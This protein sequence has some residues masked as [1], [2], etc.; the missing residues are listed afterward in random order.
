MSEANR[1]GIG[2]SLDDF[3]KEEGMLEETQAIATKETVAFQIQQ[4]IPFS[5]LK[6]A[7]LLTSPSPPTKNQR[8]AGKLPESVGIDLGRCSRGEET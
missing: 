5:A 4:A 8:L 7:P 6:K 2:T 3:L 1:Q